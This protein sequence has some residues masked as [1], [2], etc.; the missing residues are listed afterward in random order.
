MD[1]I[2]Y[3]DFKK[4]ELKVGKILE[5]EEVPGADKLLKLKVDIGTE[6]RQLIAGIKKQYQPSDLIGRYVA[7]V[8]NLA[9]RTMMGVESQGMVLAA[10]DE[11]GPVLLRPDRDVPPG[12]IIK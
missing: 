8:T 12:S 1:I 9:P 11:S 7:V 3:D 10:S 5:A 4:V 2:T 6:Q